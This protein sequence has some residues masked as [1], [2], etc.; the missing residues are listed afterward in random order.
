MKTMRQDALKLV[1]AP[2]PSAKRLALQAD[3]LQAEQLVPGPKRPE[4]RMDVSH[5]VIT[6][7]PARMSHSSPEVT[8]QQLMSHRR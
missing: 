1:I 4:R 8:L 7:S 5:T 6:L 2:L 3:Q